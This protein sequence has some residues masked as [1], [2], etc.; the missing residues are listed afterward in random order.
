MHTDFTPG[1]VNGKTVQVLICTNPYE[2]LYCAREHKGHEGIKGSP[3]EK[4]LQ[5]LI[6]YHDVTFYNYGGGHQ[7]CLAHVL[8]YLQDAIDN[9]PEL[10]WHEH[11]KNFLSGIIH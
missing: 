11:M 7:E 5:L 10:T 6:H 2:T 1:R 9:E 8:R 4:Y 3:V